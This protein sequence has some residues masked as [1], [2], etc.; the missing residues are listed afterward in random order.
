MG[1]HLN[2]T[3]QL[4]RLL[5]EGFAKSNSNSDL[6]M[7]E[8]GFCIIKHVQTVTWRWQRLTISWFGVEDSISSIHLFYI[9]STINSIIQRFFTGI[10]PQVAYKP[11]SFYLKFNHRTLCA[12]N[13]LL[14]ID[15][16]DFITSIEQISVWQQYFYTRYVCLANRIF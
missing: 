11:V 5:I 7:Y 4:Y 8:S 1:C 12:I 16:H 3:L 15:K 14:R 6:K 10:T 9:K 13:R 2:R